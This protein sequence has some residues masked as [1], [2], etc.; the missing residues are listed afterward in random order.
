MKTENIRKIA[1]KPVDNRPTHHMRRCVFALVMHT[2]AIY[3]VFHQR[4][5]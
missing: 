3:R 5:H 1:G 2:G 4:D